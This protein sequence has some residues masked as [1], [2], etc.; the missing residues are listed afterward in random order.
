VAALVPKAC[1]R[2]TFIQKTRFFEPVAGE[3]ADVLNGNPRTAEDLR[4]G[5]WLK[6]WE[7]SYDKLLR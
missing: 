3:E 7:T 4:A 2:N 1:S 5:H 6:Q